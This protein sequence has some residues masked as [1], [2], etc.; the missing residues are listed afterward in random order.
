MG[1]KLEEDGQS[2]KRG[3]HTERKV[4]EEGEGKLF[5]KISILIFFLMNANPTNQIAGYSMICRFFGKFLILN[6]LAL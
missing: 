6:F 1:E 5:S 3:D 4:G 2:E